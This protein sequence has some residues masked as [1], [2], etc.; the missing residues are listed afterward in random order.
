[1]ILGWITADE[2]QQITGEAY[3]E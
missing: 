1:M 2:Y 3:A